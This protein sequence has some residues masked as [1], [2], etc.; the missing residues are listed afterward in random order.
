MLA[1]RSFG[2]SW[3]RPFELLNQSSR[4]C[5]PR[6]A[7]PPR[8]RPKQPSRTSTASQLS[9]PPASTATKRR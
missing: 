1:Q 7:P 5:A 2:P 4:R 6:S 8:K 9:R 3:T